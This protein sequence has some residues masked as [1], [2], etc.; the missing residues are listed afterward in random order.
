MQNPDEASDVPPAPPKGKR[1]RLLSTSTESDSETDSTLWV[2]DDTLAN[3]DDVKDTVVNMDNPDIDEPSDSSE[4]EDAEEQV[5]NDLRKRFVEFIIQKYGTSEEKE[6]KEEAPKRKPRAPRQKVEKPPIKLTKVEET[7]YKSLSSDDRK[8]MFDL[9]THIANFG[10]DS[11]DI[12]YKF[13]LLRL[14]ISDYLKSNVLKKITALNDLGNEGG[15]DV[16]KLKTWIDAFFRIPFGKTVP[17]PVTL[18]DGRK[19]CT[20]FMNKS[21][22][23][24][25]NAVYGMKT[26]KTHIMQVLAQWIVN[27]KS[28]GN[29]LALQG[30]M[31]VGK[32]GFAKNAIA[33]VLNRPFQFF[34]LGGASDIANFVGHS[35]TYEGSMWGRIAD[36]IMQAG[37]MNPIMYF[38]EVDK[39]STTSHGQEIVSMLIHLTDR[40]QN[41]HFHDRYF[42]G[43]D[44]DLS[45][46]LFVFSFNDINN[47]HPILR[48]RMTVI[49][50]AGYTETDKKAILK[51]HIWPQMME[52]L[53]F[54]YKDVT[55]LDSAITF[56]ISEYS[57]EEKGVR[58]LIRAVETM[59][60]RLNMLRVSDRESMRDYKF[61]LD[62]E[63]PFIITETIVKTLLTDY[64]EKEIEVWRSLYT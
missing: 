7:Y 32:T 16:F 61:Y 24:M 8:N 44:L 62:F 6:E 25:E 11:G 35:F 59:L 55:I 17:L 45:Q 54:S 34:S 28:V 36:S 13:R 18:D 1:R 4:G 53:N 39:I 41:S 10:V 40:T 57:S 51:R 27:P 49:N 37:C 52:R 30:P 38:D 60:T 9:M 12:P 2:D 26:A 48:D 21:M 3:P 43:V 63:T 50:C 64:N 58:C 46:C 33:K 14:P 31:G 23:T 20:E 29:V 15:G 56:L 42:T 22:K 47:V 19:A 5:K